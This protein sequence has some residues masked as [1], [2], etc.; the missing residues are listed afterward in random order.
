MKILVVEDEP[1]TAATLKQGLNEK[2]YAVDVAMDGADGLYRATNDVYDAVILDVGL[3]LIDGWSILQRMRRDDQGTPV[4]MLTARDSV[5]DRV[6]GLEL[7]ADDYLIKPFAFTEMLA[8]VRRLTRRASG[9]RVESMKIGDLEIDQ[10][11]QIVIRAGRRVTLTPKEYSL[12]R[13]MAQH[14]GEVLSRTVIAER[15]WNMG[16][17]SDTNVVDVAV[18]RLRIKV[19]DPF[20]CKLIHSVR[21]MGYVLEERHGTH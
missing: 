21:G 8:R 14:A 19:D 17:D 10:L 16:F 1:M 2:G 5:D 18:R 13:F 15:V 9:Q 7:G 3:P 6:R 11:Q 12:L 20:D 4:L